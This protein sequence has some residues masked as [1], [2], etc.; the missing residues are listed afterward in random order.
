MNFDRAKQARE[1]KQNPYS[2]RRIK[3]RIIRG[4]P[5]YP[6]TPGLRKRPVTTEAIGFLHDFDR[7]HEE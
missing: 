2:D 1:Q 6:L 5:E 4:A 7:D 3:E